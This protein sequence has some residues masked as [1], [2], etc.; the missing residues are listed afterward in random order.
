VIVDDGPLVGAS[1]IKILGGASDIRVIAEAGDRA[2]ALDQSQRQAPQ[3][4][5]IEIRMPIM[6]GGLEVFIDMTRTTTVATS[7]RTATR[8]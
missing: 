6:D 3:V 1:L 5:L 7:R 4:I 2:E 8:R